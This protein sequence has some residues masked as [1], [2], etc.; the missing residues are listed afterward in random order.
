M[1]PL[2]KKYLTVP[3]GYACFRHDF[4]NPIPEEIVA[5]NANLTHFK[6]YPD[7]GHFAAFEAPKSVATDV[8]AFVGKVEQLYNG[9][10]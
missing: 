3:T 1:D 9:K 5:A 4:P 2:G 10:I 8:F 6:E 7:G